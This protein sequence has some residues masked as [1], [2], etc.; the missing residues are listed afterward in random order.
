MNIRDVCLKRW[1]GQIDRYTLHCWLAILYLS[2]RL[3]FPL[4][5]LLS[6]FPPLVHAYETEEDG[7]TLTATNCSAP[8]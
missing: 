4:F 2:I 6:V 8:H 5:P 3:I 1:R 7:N